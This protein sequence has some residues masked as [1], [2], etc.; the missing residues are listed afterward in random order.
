MEQYL[1]VE[2]DMHLFC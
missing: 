2:E 1:S